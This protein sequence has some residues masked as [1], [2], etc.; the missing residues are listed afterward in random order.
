[1][2]YEETGWTKISDESMAAYL[3]SLHSFDM[4]ICEALAVGSGC[5]NRFAMPHVGY[6]SFLF[7]Q[8]CSRGVCLI[9]AA[10][11]SR[12]KTAGFDNWDFGAAAP[13]V[14]SLGEA[15]LA[16]VYLMRPSSDEREY[17]ARITT[18][19]LHDCTKRLELFRA[20]NHKDARSFERDQEMLKERL[21][22]NP[23]FLSLAVKAQKEILKGEK[24]WMMTRDQLL[25]A[26][27]VHPLV[28]NVTWTLYSQFIHTLPMSFMRAEL[29]GR[30][31]GLEN[32]VDCGQWN[33]A[34]KV[35]TDLLERAVILMVDAF[36]DTAVLRRGIQS[37]FSPGPSENAYPVPDP[38]F[39]RDD[40]QNLA[41]K[42]ALAKNL[43]SF[44]HV[45]MHNQE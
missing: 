4:T 18:M 12:W 15:F 33:V 22:L 24:P 30:G 32:E 8:A 38:I 10:P 13:F 2:E 6:G 23:F 35:A 31:S 27:G 19:Q 44:M 39:S 11:R 3:N 36:P 37:R 9:R 16:Q 25:S 28:Y 26:A 43:A 29:Q 21:R 14:R 40:D 7:S 41:K 17:S 1:M 45:M 20:I 34:L 42:S 5:A